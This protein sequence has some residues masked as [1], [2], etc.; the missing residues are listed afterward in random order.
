MRTTIRRALI[1]PN[2]AAPRRAA[3]SNRSRS[4]VAVVGLVGGLLPFAATSGPASAA[5]TSTL[6]VDQR[7]VGDPACDAAGFP[8]YA[9]LDTTLRQ[10]F[11]TSRDGLKAVELCFNTPL[12]VSPQSLTLRV[13]ESADPEN[14]GSKLVGSKS[15][16]PSAGFGF[17]AV[18]FDTE[19]P[20]R[21]GVSYVLEIPI[22]T[23]LAVQWR[24]T[25]G[26]VVAP[27]DPSAADRYP[28]GTTNV[29]DSITPG[30]RSDFGFRS[31]PTRSADLTGSAAL[32]KVVCAGKAVG[33]ATTA[34]VTNSGPA[35][36]APFL[37][38]TYLS[39]LATLTAAAKLITETAV[40]GLAP[41]ASAAVL[42]ASA[43]FPADAAVGRGFLLVVSDP[44]DEVRESVESNN[45]LAVPTVVA[46][47]AAVIGDP[48][49]TAA[50]SD[51]A[52]GAVRVPA[53]SIPVESIAFTA[54]G[55]E[56]LPVQGLPVQG[57]PV[58]GLP[59]QGLPVQGL[60]TS[61]S[62]IAFLHGLYL[63]DIPVTGG[64]EQ[65]L[66]GTSLANTP[67]SAIRFGEFL[68][69]PD[70][71]VVTLGEVDLARSP[72]RRITLASIALAGMTYADV[73][74]NGP[75]TPPTPWCQVFGDQGYPCAEH[76]ISASSTL[77]DGDLSGVGAVIPW[78]STPIPASVAGTPLSNVPLTSYRIAQTPLRSVSLTAVRD[79]STFVSC[80]PT[81]ATLG[82]AAGSFR[83]GKT[84][85]D[86]LGA[87]L[88]RAAVLAPMRLGDLLLGI[89]G[90]RHRL[91]VASLNLHRSPTY[92][93]S[94]AT[95]TYTLGFTSTGAA[96]VVD[97][98]VVVTPP[99]G[100][101]IVPGTSQLL[102]PDA[103]SLPDP[104][105][106]PGGTL[107]WR[108]IPTLVGPGK[109]ASL[110]FRLYPGIVLGV[111]AARVTVTAVDEFG[112]VSSRTVDNI[113]AVRVVDAE[114]LPGEANDDVSSAP[115]L[116][117]GVFRLGHISRGASDSALPDIDWYRLRVPRGSAC[118][119]AATATGPTEGGCDL[120]L[121]LTTLVDDGAD[122]DLVVLGTPVTDPS[123]QGSPVQGLPV[124][125]L[126]APEGTHELNRTDD[127]P[128]DTVHDLP[129]QGLPVQGLPVQGLPV[130]GLSAQR[131][132][133]DE[134]V[135]VTSESSDTGHYVVGVFHYNGGQGPQPYV[136]T[137]DGAAAPA[138]PA[139]TPRAYNRGG[140]ALSAPAVPASTKTLVLYNHQRI[141][142]IYGPAEADL[143]LA[144]L[145][146]YAARPEVAGVVYPVESDPAVAARLAEW[147]AAPCDVPSANRVTAAVAA[148][149]T[150]LRAGLTD[151]R[152]TVLVGSDEVFP[153]ARV[154]DDVPH[155]AE[156][157][158]T[159]TL[160][161]T[162]G[163]NAITAAARTRHFLTDD[164]YAT[165][166]PMAVNGT[167]VFVPDWTV[168]RLV[169]TP[170]QVRGSLL[171]Y[172]A[173][174]G[175]AE[176]P[177]DQTVLVTGYNLLTDGGAE[178]ADALAA[179]LGA[180]KVARLICETWTRA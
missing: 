24:A 56:S 97:P 48:T 57:L 168:S 45:V 15:V 171:Q 79:A 157:S 4:W 165:S 26:T 5:T 170:A 12:G 148:L 132:T 98:T 161:A 86:L 16:T 27:C 55:A 104:V 28:R 77:V 32:P 38:R 160:V 19:L 74:P 137:V 158:Y 23:P 2:P 164:A 136:L 83:P 159:N 100:T 34:A 47:G 69:L 44:T 96:P 46:C 114:S 21:P 173:S 127:V 118:D 89:I 85:G 14:P 8:G 60:F 153:S 102:A 147:D 107:V 103:I 91:P 106:G 39:P 152:Y 95:I 146:E 94:G 37:A 115:L 138:V 13:Y 84:L 10:S 61:S 126:S 31:L 71:P 129:V 121:R 40:P 179:R 131:G 92:A 130:Q 177:P 18:T 73:A 120:T 166:Q 172:A 128:S 142:D 145:R 163:H 68:A 140:T 36:V 117:A 54:T 87:L 110:R 119:I 162:A 176:L 134:Q 101:A 62:A 169:E 63:S 109:A 122:L 124:Q 156:T 58:Q 167:P 154:H 108:D 105:M 22:L 150:G 139:C 64:W 30:P 53:T 70:E 125:G 76:G 143:L 113:G 123:V 174:N 149:Q 52:A 81:C 65:R 144:R 11:K 43:K 75:G 7:I 41:G 78:E 59:V 133:S 9:V 80:L 50:T 90:D 6:P 155:S 99:P 1:T 51:V 82:D 20:T 29:A 116:E 66:A 135:E 49:L 111:G 88:D 17:T 112:P 72:L 33:S 151:H 3:R 141:G 180:D 42:P 93:G 35:T 175:R 25:C 178:S 67:P